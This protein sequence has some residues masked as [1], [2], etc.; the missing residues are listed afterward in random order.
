MREIAIGVFLFVLCVLMVGIDIY[1]NRCTKCGGRKEARRWNTDAGINIECA[2]CGSI[3]II[4]W[5]DL[6]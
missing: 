3:E 5:E 4:P 2:L 1:F 6:H